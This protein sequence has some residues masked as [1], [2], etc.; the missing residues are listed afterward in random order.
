[1][2]HLT[3]YSV[4]SKT[5]LLPFVSGLIYFPV[6]QKMRILV[7][8]LEDVS[9]RL[10]TLEAAK[11]Q[12]PSIVEASQ[13]PELLAQ[14]RQYS[15]SLTPLARAVDDLN[16]QTALLS[17]SNV[18]VAHSTRA[19]LDD[20]NTRWKL[21]QLAVDDRYKLLSDYGRDGGPGLGLLA[22]SVESPWERATT[23]NK[24]PYYI[25]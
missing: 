1:M 4:T 13:A 8:G 18:L 24:V 14:L 16:D 11:T 9:S 6:L 3:L 17:A 21:L 19:R 10:A 15:E 20:I 7:K 12:W 25:K 22:A 2:T 23:A 5:D